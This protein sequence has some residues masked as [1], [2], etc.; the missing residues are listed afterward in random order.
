MSIEDII[1]V[2]KSEEKSEEDAPLN[3]AGEELSDEELEDVI[4]GQWCWITGCQND[5]CQFTRL[6]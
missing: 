5:T 2:W 3:P 1:K 4:G 6:W